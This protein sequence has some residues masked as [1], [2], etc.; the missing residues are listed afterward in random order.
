MTKKY[1]E[2]YEKDPNIKHIKIE[3]QITNWN[4]QS[5]DFQKRRNK[6]GDKNENFRLLQLVE[7]RLG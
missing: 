4:W 6:G 5:R 3:F 1:K 7:K 2:R